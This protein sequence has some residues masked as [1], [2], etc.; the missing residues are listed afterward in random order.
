MARGSATDVAM[1]PRA[2]HG[3][4]WVAAI[5][6]GVSLASGCGAAEEPVAP[7]A[8]SPDVP[9]PD[10]MPATDAPGDTPCTQ[11]CLSETSLRE[12]TDGERIVECPL[13]CVTAE[14]RCSAL[15]PSNG[16]GIEHLQGVTAAL[17]VSEGAQVIIDTMAGSITIA[18]ET[19]RIPGVGVNSGIGFQYT[20]DGQSVFAVQG[21]T[22]GAGSSLRA[23]GDL[24]LL[25]LSAGDIEIA[26]IIDV[27]AGCDLD[28]SAKTCG[29]P[30]GGRGADYENP[31]TGCGIGGKG[32][33]ASPPVSIGGGGGG[34][35]GQAGAGGGD[36]GF[37]AFGGGGGEACAPSLVPLRGGSGGGETGTDSGGAGGGGGGAV[38]ITSYTA[39]RLVSPAIID[40]GGSGGSVGIEGYGGG[41]GGGGGGILLEAPILS[42]DGAVLAANGGG[43]GGGAAS[44][45][46]GRR[47]AD[48]AQGG[49]STGG[50][51]G[52]LSGAPT[53]GA[54]A[55]GGGGGGGGAGLIRVHAPQANYSLTDSVTSPTPVRLDPETE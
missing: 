55:S 49:G 19:V 39:I 13:G 34:G 18:G 42:I 15:V 48:Q 52:A 21:F 24:P 35:S 44:G 33:F 28:P 5:V 36:G 54:A 8:M 32:G 45:E 38:Q 30:G 4:L 22:M 17:S 23:Q 7:D 6:A 1:A 25:I 51:G 27:S 10:A 20:D 53:A 2:Y 11:E 26:G 3:L 29:G 46:D 9:G 47:D 50:L 40:A 14:A 16:A 12:C 37:G 41:G 43:G 31:A